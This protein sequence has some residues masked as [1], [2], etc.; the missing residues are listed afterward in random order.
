M[1]NT[2]LISQS[3]FGWLCLAGALALTFFYPLGRKTAGHFVSNLVII[4]LG[5]GAAY[6][7]IPSKLMASDVTVIVLGA[8]VGLVAVI[9][10]SIL[11]WLRYFQGVVHRRTSPYYWYSRAFRPRRRRW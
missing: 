11:R 9:V 10:R 4:A 7:L 3:L 5:I 6:N 1:N 8:A 2:I